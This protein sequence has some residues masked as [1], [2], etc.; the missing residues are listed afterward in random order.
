MDDP[1]VP[2]EAA[3]EHARLVPQSEYLELDDNHFFVFMRPEKV[4]KPLANF[5]KRVENGNAKTRKTAEESRVIKSKAPFAQKVLK[6]KG[7]TVLVFFLIIVLLSLLNEDLAFLIS[8]YL[9]A[10][11]Y[12]G[13]GFAFFSSVAGALIS[14]VLF[15]LIGRRFH[16]GFSPQSE[17]AEGLTAHLKRM[18]F[19]I[20][21][22][23]YFRMGKSG[24][25]FWKSFLYLAVSAAVWS[26]LLI[27]ASYLITGFFFR[28][29]GVFS[30]TAK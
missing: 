14:I 1:L 3:R 29:R 11:G 5:W 21:S 26:I 16:P 30:I 27:T 6:A 9:A 17:A 18:I 25:G 20:H 22:L 8:G 28:I 15:M 10:Q 12:F 2:V 13:L 23:K 19:G 4:E 24:S 7:A